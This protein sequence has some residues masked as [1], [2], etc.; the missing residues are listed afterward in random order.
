VM[1]IMGTAL[2]LA[3][4]R[5]VFVSSHQERAVNIE[6]MHYLDN[7]DKVFSS[8]LTYPRVNAAYVKYNTTLP[9]SAPVDRT[10]VLYWRFDC[11][12]AN[13]QSFRCNFR[14]LAYAENE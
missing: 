5:R 2:T 12:T 9:S 3:G 8:L 13:E 14:A 6:T 4:L 10:A 7:P 11:H 1:M